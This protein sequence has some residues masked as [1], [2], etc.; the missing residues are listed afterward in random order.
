MLHELEPI[1]ADDVSHE[2]LYPKGNPQNNHKGLYLKSNPQD[3]HPDLY[4]KGRSLV[5]RR[6]VLRKVPHIITGLTILGAVYDTWLT[7]KKPEQTEQTTQP[8]KVVDPI[9]I[10]SLPEGYLE[11]FAIVDFNKPLELDTSSFDDRPFDIR[12][13]N[14]INRFRDVDLDRMFAVTDPLIDVRKND[15]GRN[16]PWLLLTAYIDSTSEERLTGGSFRGIYI[17][18]TPRDQQRYS[19]VLHRGKPYALQDCTNERI[20]YNRENNFVRTSDQQV[21]DGKTIGAISQNPKALD[22]FLKTLLG[23]G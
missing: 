18:M 11:G 9:I 23:R 10:P 17:N 19:P 5:T 15:E 1:S 6:D 22:D 3:M 7:N 2:D 12:S 21:I 13:I 4:P 20:A 16:S 8:E 14:F